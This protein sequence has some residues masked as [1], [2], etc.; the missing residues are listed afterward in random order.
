MNEFVLIQACVPWGF[1]GSEDG[2]ARTLTLCG[3]IRSHARLN[4][5]LFIGTTGEPPIR[6]SILQLDT[7]FFS[8]TFAIHVGTIY[9]TVSTRTAFSCDDLIPKPHKRVMH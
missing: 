1:G 7:D 5:Q 2:Q 3:T 4:G 9:I 8:N 6:R